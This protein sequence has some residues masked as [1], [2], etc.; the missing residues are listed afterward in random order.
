MNYKGFAQPSWV[1]CMALDLLKI[2]QKTILK[3]YTPNIESAQ[4]YALPQNQC[5]YPVL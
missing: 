5:R 4:I 3:T 1:D 2:T